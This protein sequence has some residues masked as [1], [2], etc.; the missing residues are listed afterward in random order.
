[1]LRERFLTS[2]MKVIYNLSIIKLWVIAMLNKTE[3]LD[4]AG[5]LAKSI[6]DQKGVMNSNH[7]GKTSQEFEITKILESRSVK[8]FIDNLTD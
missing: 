3:L 6:L 5:K 1:M 8:N 7:R 4:L 2:I